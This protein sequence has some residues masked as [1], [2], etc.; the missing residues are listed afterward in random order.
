MNEL[1]EQ[2]DTEQLFGIAWR[3]VNEETVSEAKAFATLVKQAADLVVKSG[4][5]IMGVASRDLNDPDA[6]KIER[7][8]K[9]YSAVEDYTK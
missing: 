5:R 9:D 1:F 6:E 4:K 2:L 3:I 7:I 8:I